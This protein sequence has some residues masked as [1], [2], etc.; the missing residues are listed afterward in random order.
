M[1]N[2][3]TAD[4]LAK[5]Q[6]QANALM[7]NN[8]KAI[9]AAAYYT[10]MPQLI[11]RVIHEDKDTANVVKRI[12][13]RVLTKFPLQAMWHLA[14]LKGS[15]NDKRM[16]IGKDIFTGAQKALIK[17]RQTEKVANLLKESDSLFKFLR[18]LA[19]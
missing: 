15:S 14:W 4:F 1:F 8:T 17:N 7:V 16:N 5:N 19:R 10:A 2:L 13:E 12:L 11:S 3:T 18:D 6:D 9:P